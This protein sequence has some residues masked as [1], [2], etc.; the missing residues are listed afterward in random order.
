MQEA[1]HRQYG[2]M[3]EKAAAAACA[4]YR[5]NPAQRLYLAF[6]PAGSVPGT[7]WGTLHVLAKGTS[8]V[9]AGMEYARASYLP[10]NLTDADMREEIERICGH[11][12][13]VGE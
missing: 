4:L 3:V 9:E 7:T 13:L 12:P 2:Q 10:R 11:L 6:R 1:W 5:E 8:R